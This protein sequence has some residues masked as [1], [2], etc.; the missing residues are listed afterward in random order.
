[1]RVPASVFLIPAFLLSLSGCFDD[2]AD[3]V[4]ASQTGE[5]PAPQL[6]QQFRASLEAMSGKGALDYQDDGSAVVD[7]RMWMGLQPDGRDK[8]G[9]MLAFHAA[10][11]AKQSS[12]DQRVIIRN[13]FGGVIT[14]RTIDTRMNMMS[15]MGE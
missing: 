2:P 6:C 12:A 7:E 15:M 4:Q 5:P 10:C 3:D 9:Q 14:R 8:I 1:M 11:A 13:Q